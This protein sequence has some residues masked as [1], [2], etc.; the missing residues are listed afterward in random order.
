MVMNI[1]RLKDRDYYYVF[2]EISSVAKITHS[3][4]RVLKVILE[5]ALL[6][7]EEIIDAC[8]ISV[9]AGAHFVKTSTGTTLCKKCY[10]FQILQLLSFLKNNI[11]FA[12]NC[13]VFVFPNIFSSS[14][15]QSFNTN[16]IIDNHF[17]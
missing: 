13:Y 16:H 12:V 11:Q 3:H 17:E 4:N 7:K 8:I 9:L 15:N 5:C 14:V 6:T 1:G 10:P 2:N